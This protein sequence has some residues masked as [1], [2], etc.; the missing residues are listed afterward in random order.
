MATLSQNLKMYI[1]ISQI[2][3]KNIT[4]TAVRTIPILAIPTWTFYVTVNILNDYIDQ[5][6]KFN[7]DKPIVVLI[8]KNSQSYIRLKAGTPHLD[9][10]KSM[11]KIDYNKPNTTSPKRKGVYI[12]TPKHVLTIKII[13]PIPLNDNITKSFVLEGFG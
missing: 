1:Y 10:N 9:K 7:S 4:C 8:P 5:N 12:N 2:T 6:V 3:V 13:E 11:I